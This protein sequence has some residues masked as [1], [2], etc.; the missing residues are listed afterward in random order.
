MVCLHHG[1]LPTCFAAVVTRATKQTMDSSLSWWW[2]SFL[3]SPTKRTIRGGHCCY[4]KKILHYVQEQQMNHDI[5]FS[6]GGSF[7]QEDTPMIPTILK[8]QDSKI[9]ICFTSGSGDSLLKGDDIF[10]DAIKAFRNMHPDLASQTSIYKVGKIGNVSLDNITQ[11][12]IMNQADLDLF[13]Q[14][15]IDIYIN[16]ETGI[17]LNG[18]PLGIE[19]L[20]QGAVGVM[21]NSQDNYYD[22]WD[23]SN[24]EMF[25]VP[26]GQVGIPDIVRALAALV[27]DRHLLNSMSQKSQKKIHQLL[28]FSNGQAKVFEAIEKRILMQRNQS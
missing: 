9:G 2:S 24:E 20:L 26:E 6:L 7:L 1:R 16:T 27:K 19:A 23:F 17:A 4:A 21:T 18:W 22:S 3:Q 5:V 10:I 14:N 15:S 28:S 25:I 13:Y 12:G 8:S 11:T